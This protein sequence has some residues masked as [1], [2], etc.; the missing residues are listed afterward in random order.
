MSHTQTKELNKI[1]LGS[2]DVYITEWT[3]TIP[4]NNVIE[5]EDNMA[6]R[7]KNG[8]T[9]S[10]GAEWYVAESDDG[11][12]KKRRIVSESAS[13]SYGNITWNGNTLEKY[14][15][16]ARIEEKDGKRITKIGGVQNDNGKRYLIRGVHH[17]PVD[18]DIRITGVGVNTGGWE[19]AFKPDSETIIQPTFEL[20]PVLDDSGTLLTYEEEVIES[21]TLEDEK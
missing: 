12:A 20:E 1:P 7:I 19:A 18:G 2:M 17:D 9:I 8:A 16:T 6:G 11:K 14:I 4:E 3:G 15:A 21:E 5:T 13:I 10:Y